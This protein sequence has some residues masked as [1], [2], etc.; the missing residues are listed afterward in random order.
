LHLTLLDAVALRLEA[1]QD[2]M[3]WRVLARAAG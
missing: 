2:V 3:G 1:G